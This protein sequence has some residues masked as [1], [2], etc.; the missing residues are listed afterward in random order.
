MPRRGY[1]YRG[2]YFKDPDVFE[3]VEKLCKELGISLNKL[4]NIFFRSV[5]ERSE[6]IKIDSRLY[7][8]V[9]GGINININQNTVVGKGEI[10]TMLF[11]ALELLKK[12]ARSNNIVKKTAFERQ[13][14]DI[15]KNIIKNL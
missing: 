3:K 6:N 9:I 4:V 10:K 2:F 1:L 5:A 7:Q 14:I 8:V 12:A 15:I 13:A 11:E